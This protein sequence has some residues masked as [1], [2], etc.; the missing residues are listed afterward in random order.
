MVTVEETCSCGAQFKAT[1]DGY[2]EAR[3]SEDALEAWRADHKH[4]ARI[5][6]PAYARATGQNG[7]G[8]RLAETYEGDY[9]TGS[10][11][12]EWGGDGE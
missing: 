7:Y 12:A 9:E 10:D 6:H 8:K 5:N 3:N 1:Y 2:G 4:E 11:S